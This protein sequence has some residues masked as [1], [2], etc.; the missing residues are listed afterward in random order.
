MMIVFS[1]VI[2]NTQ[3][4][5]CSLHLVSKSANGTSVGQSMLKNLYN[6]KVLFQCAS[7]GCL[8]LENGTRNL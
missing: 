2:G 7:N 6:S 8:A 1:I 3:C 4:S 5:P